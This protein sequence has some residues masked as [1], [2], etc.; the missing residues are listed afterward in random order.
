L[1]GTDMNIEWSWWHLAERFCASLARPKTDIAAADREV[2]SILRASWLWRRSEW[3][4]DALR[5]AWRES[6]CR[7]TLISVER[8]IRESE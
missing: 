8:A 6:F 3:L 2:E 7:R 4:A 5:A 1:Q